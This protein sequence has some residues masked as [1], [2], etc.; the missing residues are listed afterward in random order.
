[1]INMRQKYLKDVVTLTLDIDRCIGCGQ[2][3]N[4]CPH[5]VFAMDGDKAGILSRDNCMECGACAINCPVAAL[6]VNAGVGCAAA[7]IQGWLTGK[8]PACC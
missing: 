8:E 2:C 7:I 4:V 1:M 6:A 5:Q 3:I